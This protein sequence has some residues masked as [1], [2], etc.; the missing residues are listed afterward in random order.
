MG[1]REPPDPRSPEILPEV[2]YSVEGKIA[3]G[4]SGYWNNATRLELA[5][6][7]NDRGT[8]TKALITA[9]RLLPAQARPARGRVAGDP[10]LSGPPEL[11]P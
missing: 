9:Q 3:Q 4:K 6:L 1:L 8:A 5:V 11:H 7:L 2:R 10:L